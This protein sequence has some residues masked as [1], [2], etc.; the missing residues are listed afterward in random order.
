MIISQ[1]SLAG[2]HLLSDLDLLYMQS[3][4]LEFIFTFFLN[5]CDMFIYLF[6]KERC[7]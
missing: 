4:V 5:I 6:K 1:T 3:K 7:L 2:W